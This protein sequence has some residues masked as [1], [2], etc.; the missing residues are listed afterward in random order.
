MDRACKDRAA[1]LDALML[2]LG[3]GSFAVLIGY[4]VLCD[5]L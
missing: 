5:R 2:V 4:A 3:L 1:M